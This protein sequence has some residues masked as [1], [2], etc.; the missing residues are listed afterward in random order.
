M[1][2][3]K[4]ARRGRTAALDAL[5]SA[6]EWTQAEGD[7]T[8]LDRFRGAPLGQGWGEK[9]TLVV[10]GE[11][12]S[13]R[14]TAFEHAYNTTSS[15]GTGASTS[16]H[17][18]I[19]IAVETPGPGLG[20]HIGAE[21][22]GR[23][24]LSLFGARDFE[25]G[26]DPFD[27]RFHVRVDDGEDAEAFA[28]AVLNPDLRAWLTG[29]EGGRRDPF[30]FAGAQAITWHSGRMTAGRLIEGLDYLSEILD[31]VPATAWREE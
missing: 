30:R 31:R 21:H 20:L 16:T 11:H 2:T 12:R 17:R 24:I 8:L 14:F 7:R 27:R 29:A 1:G 15:F 5:V 4:S 6:Q 18:N 19:V 13:H 10:S 28:R 22:I 23:R 26:D 3:D 9:V 25:L